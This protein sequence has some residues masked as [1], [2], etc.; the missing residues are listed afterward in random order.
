LKNLLYLNIILAVF[1][2]QCDKP[3]NHIEGSCIGFIETKGKILGN[4]FVLNNPNIVVCTYHEIHKDSTN[5]IFRREDGMTFDL[6][7][8]ITIQSDDIALL[9]A[10]SNICNKPLLIATE[11]ELRKRQP[12]ILYIRSL[13]DSS[14]FKKQVQIG[15]A[16]YIGRSYLIQYNL[17]TD[18]GW[19]GAPILNDKNFVVGLHTGYMS[20]FSESGVK[21]TISFGYTLHLLREYLASVHE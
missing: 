8:L 4:A 7:L 20:S 15:D 6:K 10:D 18:P 19:S 1:A 5:L 9:V 21:D 11:F 14:L 16:G 17:R 2:V 3:I 13:S 12:I